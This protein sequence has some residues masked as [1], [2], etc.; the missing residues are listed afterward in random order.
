MDVEQKNYQRL[1]KCLLEALIKIRDEGP[2][3]PRYGI[4]Y[5]VETMMVDRDFTVFIYDEI[6]D[7][8]HG[9]EHHSGKHSYPVPSTDKR[10]DS[11]GYY[12]TRLES[13][14]RLWRH[15]QGMFR[16]DLVRYMINRL[17]QM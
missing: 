6:S 15:K 12:D 3:S 14:D 16:T 5:N 17:E 1:Q 7:L 13:P 9:W 2:E 11:Q 8:S 4:C 10:Y